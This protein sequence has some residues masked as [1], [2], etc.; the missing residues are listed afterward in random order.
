MLM[1]L[2]CLMESGGYCGFT[3]VF[4]PGVERHI[5]VFQ[6]GL[7]VRPVSKSTSCLV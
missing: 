3:G 6:V 1:Y 7:G 5:G 4:Q 2:L